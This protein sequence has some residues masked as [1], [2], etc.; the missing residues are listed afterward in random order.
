MHL[1]ENGP[2]L[3]KGVAQ[4]CSRLPTPGSPPSAGPPSSRSKYVGTDG[5]R[6]APVQHPQP[7]AVKDGYDAH[8][9]QPYSEFQQPSHVRQQFPGQQRLAEVQDVERGHIPTSCHTAN[10]RTVRRNCDS[11]DG[12]LTDNRSPNNRSPQAQTQHTDRMFTSHNTFQTPGPDG[13]TMQKP[14]DSSNTSP[15]YTKH[16]P[17]EKKVYAERYQKTC[18]SNERDERSAMAQAHYPRGAQWGNVTFHASSAH[19]TDI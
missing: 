11:S 4:G 1:Y 10:P 7:Q 9:G 2:L 18:H 5:Q 8:S 3:S 14:R 17:Y 19:Q 15:S 13:R 12:W 16:P 6:S